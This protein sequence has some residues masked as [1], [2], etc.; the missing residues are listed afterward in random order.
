MRERER[1][2]E[3]G[4]ESKRKSVR[5]RDRDP[6]TVTANAGTGV[7]IILIGILQMSSL[8]WLAMTSWLVS[9]AQSPL[10]HAEATPMVICSSR[11][12]N[13][14]TR[15]AGQQFTHNLEMVCKIDLSI[16]GSFVWAPIHILF[17][18]RGLMVSI[19][20]K[21]H[22]RRLNLWR[23][24]RRRNSGGTLV[25]NNVML[26]LLT[27]ASGFKALCL[28][29]AAIN[30]CCCSTQCCTY[31]KLLWIKVSAKWPKC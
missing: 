30:T 9:S 4:K 15:A 29:F 11:T 19:L 18:L 14:T 2:R 23:R 24:R 5:G 22:W 12:H 8:Y 31:C 17:F 28:D 27:S 26:P 20:Y 21:W 7:R 3:R 1:E 25:M 10:D 13:Q 16:P 6:T